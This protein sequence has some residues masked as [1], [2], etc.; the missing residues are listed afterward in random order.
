MNKSL[1]LIGTYSIAVLFV[2]MVSYAYS[3][4]V[5]TVDG[6]RVV[7]NEKAGKWGK[8]PKVSLEFVKAVGDIESEDENVLF[9][10]P[11]DIV[12]D[13]QGNMYILDTGNHRIQ[14]FAP[15]GKFIASIGRKGQ[16][17]AEFQYPL[18]LDVDSEGYLYVADSGNQRIQVL[19]PDGTDHKTIQM[20]K[21]GI[22][23][24]K[25][26][27]SG[28][29]I[30][31]SGGFMMIGPGGMNEDED[32][33]NL[34]KVLNLEGD[35]KKEFGKQRDYKDFMMN[36]MGN[37]FHYTVDKNNN[38]YISFD[39][40]N[41]IEKYSSDGKIHWISDR[42]LN[43]DTTSPKKGR[44]IRSGG[45]RMIQ[46]PDMKK[47][48][49]GIA[50]DGKGRIW[51]VTLKRQIKEDERVAANV[52]V[53][54]E[55]GGVRNMKMSVE[56][57]TDVRETDMYQLEVYAPDGILLGKLQLNQFVDDIRIQKDRI[58]L[59]DKMRGMQYYEYKIIEK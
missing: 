34:I 39:Y 28:D 12:F 43:Y 31:G 47:C 18:S 8:Q 21:I 5:E 20:T 54:V 10:L 59:L 40:Q 16:G 22:G 25:V 46:A 13:T 45:N 32:L 57:N 17:P 58:Y 7:H 55:P 36:R 6:V 35:V 4:K 15:D 52:Q 19:N 11:S 51:V 49:S 24:I 26:T 50:I 9:Y 38:I 42:K 29:M 37:Q 48:S 23:P 33:P 14:K 27:K 30:M 56:G 41:R 3:Q 1:R 44:D 53:M 2:L